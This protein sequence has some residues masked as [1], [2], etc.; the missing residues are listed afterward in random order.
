MVRLGLGL[1]GRIDEVEETRPWTIHLSFLFVI[2][3]NGHV[4]VLQN[5][6]DDRHVF[7]VL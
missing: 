6:T 7:V 2:Y 1:G 4:F 3:R 5:R